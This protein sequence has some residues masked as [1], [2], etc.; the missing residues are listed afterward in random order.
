MMRPR[1]EPAAV[2]ALEFSDETA[3]VLEA[4]AAIGAS[5]GTHAMLA[6]PEFS[7]HSAMNAIELMDAKLDFG[8]SRK[9]L[10]TPAQ[11]IARG[12]LPLADLTVP[13]VLGIAD[14]LLQLEVSAARR[15]AVG[16]SPPWRRCVAH[17]PRPTRAAPPRLPVTCA[18]LVAGGQLAATDA[19]DVHV[20][21]PGGAADDARHDGARALGGQARRLG[22][23]RGR[24]E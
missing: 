9:A 8:S 18:E 14:K 15:Q 20:R 3:A 12:E 17:T 10:S 22:G 2:A 24:E 6:H 11:R 16:Q 7:L 4:A 5:A 21:A 1:L 13:A 23:G 19:H